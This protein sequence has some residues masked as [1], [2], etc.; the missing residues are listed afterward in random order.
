MLLSSTVKIIIYETSFRTL[1]AASFHK[2][3]LRHSDKMSESGF[4]GLKDKKDFGL[5]RIS[6][7]NYMRRESCNP[8]NQI[9]L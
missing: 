7:K 4:S 8:K 9:I 6:I 3:A 1:P 2:Y 5:E